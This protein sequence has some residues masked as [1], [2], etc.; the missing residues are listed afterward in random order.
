MATAPT[1]L[2]ASLLKLSQAVSSCFKLFHAVSTLSLEKQQDWHSLAFAAPSLRTDYRMARLA[3]KRSGLALEVLTP[4]MRNDRPLVLMAVQQDCKAEAFIWAEVFPVLH[5]IPLYKGSYLQSFVFLYY[6][7]VAFPYSCK[8]LG[9]LLYHFYSFVH[10]F[11]FY[12]D[13]NG[14]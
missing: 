10:R 4:E 12:V 1:S 7:T 8:Y 11:L 6:Y 5:K 14:V 13:F 9:F 2:A 3:V